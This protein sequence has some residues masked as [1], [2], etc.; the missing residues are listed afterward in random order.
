MCGIFGIIFH[1][2]NQ[3]P[4]LDKLNSS[5][6]LL[7]HRGP[8]AQNV[9]TQEGIA[10]G[11]TRLTL[12]DQNPRSN[13][14]FWDSNNRYCL[15]YN[16]E[17]YNFEQLRV[18]LEMHGVKFRTSSDT[19]V[20]L[21][22]LIHYGV[23]ITLSKLEGMFAFAFFDQQRELL[24]L[25]R[26]RFGI[27][28]L[29]ICETDEYFIFSSE[30]KAMR[31]WISFEPDVFSIS[32]YLQGF[33]GPT[34]KHSF[35]QNIHIVP[36][37]NK[38]QIRRGSRAEYQNFSSIEEFFDLN[39]QE[40][41]KGLTS[42]Q[43]INELDSLLHDSVKSQLIADFPVGGLCSG[44]VDS[45]LILAIAKNYHN[46]LA[47]FHA[48]VIGK[49]S[50]YDAA[51]QLAKHLK[52]DLISVNVSDQDFIDNLI[53]V[54][55]HYEHP[56]IY[57]P[58]SI[59]F[60]KVAKLTKKNGIKAVLTGEGSDESFHGYPW[61]IFDLFEYI[62]RIIRKPSKLYQLMIRMFS[63]SSVEQTKYYSN[64]YL[65][66]ALHNR[67]EIMLEQ[68]EITENIKNLIGKDL[69]EQD[70]LSPFWLSYHLRTLLHRNDCLGMAA[71]IESR[72][73]YLNSKVVKFALNMPYNYKVKFSASQLNKEHIFLRDKW[74]IRKIASRYLPS[75]LA[76]RYKMGFPV[77]AFRRI[78]VKSEFFRNSFIIDFFKL[79]H[80]ELDF[81][82]QN[83][84][85]QLKYRLMLLEIWAQVCV[86]NTPKEKLRSKIYN[87]VSI[88]P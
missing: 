41:L 49:H 69:K 84:D 74:I 68:H 72:F 64:E 45:S 62:N 82:L 27:K 8:D 7:Q 50:E 85:Q 5:I 70:L 13:Q 38:I 66:Q 19:E 32:S 21:E 30:I 15:V 51:L 53:E 87:Q 16:G 86:F 34:K 73:P 18:E 88:K 80:K 9:Y 20:L 26:D 24:V 22:C 42:N 37:G 36:P 33:S 76:Y 28:P 81:F 79:S 48:N 52:L 71:S 83:S 3:F 65:V 2:R 58:S 47:I 25:V 57:H 63:N 11:H 59:P 17:I 35:Y 46:N 75:N 43:I 54:T 14:P 4:D 29:Y 1:N 6:R 55:E 10:L 39:E 31:P 12:L 61:M 23:D 56:F 67:F 78:T 40:R 77:S 60:L 44:G